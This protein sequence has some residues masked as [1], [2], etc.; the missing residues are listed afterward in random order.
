MILI[1]WL[2]TESTREMA[3][4]DAI[5]FDY[6]SILL[7]GTVSEG[8][9]TEATATEHPVEDDADITDHVRPSLRRLTL[10]VVVTPHAGASL[11]HI[12]EPGT[13][14][15][16]S[17]PRTVRETLSDLIANG[18]EVS[19]E[20]GVLS[21]ESMLLLSMS[22][23]RTSDGGDGFRASLSARE[24]RR[25]STQEVEAPSPRVERGRRRT[26]RGRQAGA[27][28]EGEAP[29]S[30]ERRSVA[31]SGLRAAAPALGGLVSR[32]GGGS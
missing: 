8:Y 16:T 31:M 20:S 21:W 23:T 22:E 12:V 6:Q 14:A 19:I 28:A 27:K 32:L 7:D 30:A 26:D 2:A 15:A 17:R 3:G 1:S 11:A 5:D 25:V 18:T 10:E 13:E 29:T 9:D 24:I 4:G